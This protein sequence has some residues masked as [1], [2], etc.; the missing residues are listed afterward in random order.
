M[1]T[2]F[3]FFEGI[4][5]E[6]AEEPDVEQWE[7]DMEVERILTRTGQIMRRYTMEWRPD[8]VPTIT[9]INER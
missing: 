2:E 8:Y 3:K 5:G 4:V 1:N 6:Y 9:T 7:N